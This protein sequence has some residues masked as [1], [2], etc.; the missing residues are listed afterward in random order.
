MKRIFSWAWGFV[1][2]SAKAYVIVVLVLAGIGGL[3]FAVYK[4]RQSGYDACEADHTAAVVE[5]KD[6]SRGK[7]IESGKKYETIKAEIVRQAG[8]NDLAGPRTSLAIDRMP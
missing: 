8:P 5:Q 4:I 7:I 3:G 2:D 1:P 6:E